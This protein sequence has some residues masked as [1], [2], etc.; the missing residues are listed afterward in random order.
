VGSKVRTNVVIDNE[1]VGRVMDTFGLPS[2]RAA[3]DFALRAVL[4]E[5]EE[6]AVTDPGKAMLE[7]RGIW[8][9]MTDEEA[10][11]IWGDEVPDGPNAGRSKRR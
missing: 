11:E 7:L 10:R 4:G 3:I 9:D 2:K 8:A 1:L 6:E 5:P